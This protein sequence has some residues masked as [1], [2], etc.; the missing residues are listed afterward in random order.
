RA[1]RAQQNSDNTRG[2]DVTEETLQHE[3]AH[4]VLFFIGFHNEKAMLQGANPRWLAEGIAQL[5]EPID[6][7]EGSGIGKVN[8]DQAAQFHRL[9]EA[10]AL[11]PIDGFVSDIRYFGV[12]NPALQAYPQSWA[13]AHYLTRTKRKEL[14]A[15]LD[16]IN[17][18]GGDYEM[19]P[20]KDLACFEKY[21]G[22]VDE[23]WI[24]RFKDYMARVN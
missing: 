3:V 15:Y 23:S 24:K 9:V 14:K 18:R 12:G 16:E 21:F 11:F 7:G 8:R 17:T 6:V 10:D 22:K 5:F 13:L 19:D 20:E 4:Q 1:L 2:G